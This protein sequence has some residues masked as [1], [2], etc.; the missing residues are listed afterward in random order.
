M[1]ADRFNDYRE[2]SAK[3]ADASASC[4]HPIR[5]GDRIGW[6]PRNK[7]THCAE[8]WRKWT[9]ENADAASAERGY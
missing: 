6:N 4:G 9:I 8:C 3:R 2:L 1:S 7:R 5:V